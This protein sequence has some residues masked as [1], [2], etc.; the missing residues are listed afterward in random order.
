MLIKLKRLT[1]RIVNTTW[2]HTKTKNKT[3]HFHFLTELLFNVDVYEYNFF[4]FFL[5]FLITKVEG[6]FL[7]SL[8]PRTN[9]SFSFFT[10]L[11]IFS[12][13]TSFFV[14]LLFHLF[15][16]NKIYLIIFVKNFDLTNLFSLLSHPTW[17]KHCVLPILL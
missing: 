12:V 13:E 17:Y 5:N 6:G 16:Y 10:Y 15:V 8:S 14:W 7:R 1:T 2:I 3:L 9:N 4:F 11:F